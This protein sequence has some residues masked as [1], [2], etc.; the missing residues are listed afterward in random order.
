MNT[1]CFNTAPKRLLPTTEII[2]HTLQR[3]LMTASVKK[4]QA[5]NPI[6][7]W[8]LRKK[9]KKMLKKA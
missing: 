4:K 2:S 1:G 8:H 5:I 6:L 3:R 7:R 9:P